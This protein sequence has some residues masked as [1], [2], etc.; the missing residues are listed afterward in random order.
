M[1]VPS[2]TSSLENKVPSWFFGGGIPGWG[3]L[4]ASQCKAVHWRAGHVPQ[5]AVQSRGESLD[6]L[7]TPPHGEHPSMRDG[8]GVYSLATSLIKVCPGDMNFL[9]PPSSV[10]R[11]SHIP[12]PNAPSES[13]KDGRSRSFDEPSAMALSARVLVVAS[14]VGIS[15]CA[16]ASHYLGEGRQ[17]G[18]MGDEAAATVAG[19]S[20]KE[21][22]S[23]EARDAG[24]VWECAFSDS[25][26][27]PSASQMHSLSVTSYPHTRRTGAS[28]FFPRA[29]GSTSRCP[30]KL[31]SKG[32]N[33]PWLTYVSITSPMPDFFNTRT[34]TFWNS[35]LVHCKPTSEDHPRKSIAWLH[36]V[37]TK[38][39]NPKLWVNAQLL[40]F[41]TSSSTL[42]AW[43]NSL[44]YFHV[45]SPASAGTL[46]TSCNPLSVWT[47]LP[48]WGFVIP[49]SGGAET[50]LEKQWGWRWG[51]RHTLRIMNFAKHL[52]LVEWFCGVQ[53]RK[54]LEKCFTVVILLYY[55][56]F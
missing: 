13:R 19:L 45:R 31:H 28:P 44:G 27:S 55:I 43:S 7:S 52:H 30:W 39:L 54:V 17:Q 5:V 41:P 1:A 53:A 6:R 48:R 42:S 33:Q 34:R 15:W 37:H 50:S 32:K 40:E 46:A 2:Q 47:V 10:T 36:V 56:A 8:R 20:T 11:S 51:G 29:E 9:A 16:G 3:K 21:L 18:A 14:R 12:Q 4:G 38:I 25:T 23:G 24:P 49:S 35:Q 26:L 22:H